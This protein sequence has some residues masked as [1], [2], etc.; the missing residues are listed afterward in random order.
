MLIVVND[1]GVFSHH[2]SRG[3]DCRSSTP[4]PTLP[5]LKEWSLLILMIFSGGTLTLLQS[6]DGR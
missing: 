6:L 4:D 1:D 3:G 2:R 5:M